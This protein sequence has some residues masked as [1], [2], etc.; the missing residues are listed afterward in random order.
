MR[1]VLLPNSRRLSN[2]ISCARF[3]I[4]FSSEAT[5]AVASDLTPT[6]SDCSVVISEAISSRDIAPLRES[7]DDELDTSPP[8]RDRDRATQAECARVISEGVDGRRAV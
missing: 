2:T 5:F 6:S 1:S 3:V 4:V 8:I 7:D